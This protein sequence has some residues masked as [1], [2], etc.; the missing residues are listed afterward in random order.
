MTSTTPRLSLIAA[1][2]VVA[3]VGAAAATAAP[4]TPADAR[5]FV[6]RAEAE[7]LDLWIAAERTSPI[8]RAMARAV[9]G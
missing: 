8:S 6:E 7:L 2:A 3:L 4:P 1:L 5:A 9:R